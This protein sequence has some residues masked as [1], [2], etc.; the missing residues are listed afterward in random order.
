MNRKDLLNL[1]IG[2][3]ILDFLFVVIY[4]IGAQDRTAGKDSHPA[5]RHAP[6]GKSK[7]YF[8]TSPWRKRARLA[9]YSLSTDSA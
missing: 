9:A 4:F 2:L 3:T 8:W 6:A 7:R 5:T 1:V